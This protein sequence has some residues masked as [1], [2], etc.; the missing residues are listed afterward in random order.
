MSE[1][2]MTRRTIGLLV[3]LTLGLLVAPLSTE[4]QRTQKKVPT[5]GVLLP[6]SPPSVPDWKRHWVFLQ[7]LR[8]LGWREG[9]NITVEYRWASGGMATIRRKLG[10]FEG[11]AVFHEESENTAYRQMGRWPKTDVFQPRL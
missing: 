7:E 1:A 10:H 5:I 3:T 8:T 4:A 11:T 6:W 9:E 2:S